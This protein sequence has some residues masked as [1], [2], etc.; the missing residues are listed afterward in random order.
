MT[1][2][3]GGSHLRNELRKNCKRKCWKEKLELSMYEEKNVKVKIIILSSLISGSYVYSVV[4]SLLLPIIL[5]ILKMMYILMIIVVIIIIVLLL[6]LL[7]MLLI[8]F[9]F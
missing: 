5:L 9:V 7:W 1:N 8:F 3:I 4:Q 6:F 2:T